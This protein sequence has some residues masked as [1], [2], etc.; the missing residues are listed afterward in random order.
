[1]RK[2]TD[3]ETLALHLLNKYGSYCP[4]WDAGTD[5]LLFASALQRLVAKK[6]VRVEQTDGGFRYWPLSDA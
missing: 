5:A 4:P 6:R 3:A 2:L 1:M